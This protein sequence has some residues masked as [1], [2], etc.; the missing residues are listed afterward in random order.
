MFYYVYLLRS[1][2]DGQLYTGC[3]NNLKRHVQ[4]HQA[5]QVASTQHRLPLELAYYEAC[6]NQTDAT[7]RE[8]YLKTAW[9]T[10]KKRGQTIVSFVFVL[11]FGGRRS[12]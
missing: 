2:S 9:G 11:T 10:K 8:K 6:R 1:R 7:R 4:E 12:K 3:T 5:G